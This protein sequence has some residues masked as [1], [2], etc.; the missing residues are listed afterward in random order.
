MATTTHQ[1]SPSST[2]GRVALWAVLVLCLV[3]G[4]M[5][6][7][8]GA[9]SSGDTRLGGFMIAVPAAIVA[10]LC[11]YGISRMNRR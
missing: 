11:V 9:G 5:F 1:Q 2:A 10:A 3:A 4:A 7:V 6:F 8:V